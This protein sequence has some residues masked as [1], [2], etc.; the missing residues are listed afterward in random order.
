M[1]AC[2]HYSISYFIVTISVV[3]TNGNGFAVL[4]TR[5][6]VSVLASINHEAKQGFKDKRHVE[7]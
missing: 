7:E 5:I 2:P 4:A 1:H 6:E 3:F